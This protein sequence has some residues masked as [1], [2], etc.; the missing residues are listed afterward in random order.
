MIS[1]WWLVL[2]VLVAACASPQ[3]RISAGKSLL[4]P[5]YQ[6]TTLLRAEGLI[7]DATWKDMKELAIIVNAR[8]LE[9]QANPE[10]AEFERAF[11]S[12]YTLY[13]ALRNG[14]TGL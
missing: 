14:R 5:V 10:N 4:T 9:W 11:Q 3:E 13:V 1:K 8:L 2:V 12:A 6:G 7:D